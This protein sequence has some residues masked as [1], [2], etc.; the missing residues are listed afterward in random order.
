MLR[1]PLDL[2][3]VTKDIWY[4]KGGEAQRR[5]GL[6]L[7]FP[8][9]TTTSTTTSGEAHKASLSFPPQDETVLPTQTCAPRHQTG[10]T[11]PHRHSSALPRSPGGLYTVSWPWLGWY[12]SVI[13]KLLWYLTVCRVGVGHIVPVSVTASMEA[14]RVKGGS[15][16]TAAG[17]ACYF[18]TR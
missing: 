9:A 10:P 11:Y 18:Q 6:I 8:Y 15:E 16:I 4:G 1:P 12:A 17:H 14:L 5:L 13:R 2:C 3:T 7:F